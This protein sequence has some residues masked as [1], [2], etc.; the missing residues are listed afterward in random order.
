M[1]YNKDDDSEAIAALKE[2]KLQ[3]LRQK[4]D[5]RKLRL[6]KGTEI[7]TKEL[8]EEESI[9]TI[10]RKF[11]SLNREITS[12]LQQ[13]EDVNVPMESLP[14]LFD[15]CHCKLE[16]WQKTISLT[17]HVCKFYHKRRFQDIY[18]ELNERRQKL[19]QSLMPGKQF[20]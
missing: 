9:D 18:N 8:V 20:R 15:A 12:I 17:S 7:K 5:E 4:N 19:E 13:I 11:D 2:R 10:I 14:E 1:D 16:E 3:I 6:Q